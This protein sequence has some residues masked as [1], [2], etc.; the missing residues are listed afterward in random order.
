VCA[1]TQVF[2]LDFYTVWSMEYSKPWMTFNVTKVN[3]TN[4][5]AEDVSKLKADLAA[6]N[7]TVA[8]LT[9]AFLTN[10]TAVNNYT[11]Y[12]N[13][14]IGELNASM[15]ALVDGLGALI[16]ELRENL[17]AQAENIT[18]LLDDVW[19]LRENL[20]AYGVDEA[21]D[22]D[23]LKAQLDAL[24][25]SLLE[26]YSA[27]RVL[28]EMNDTALKELA[29]TNQTLLKAAIDASYANLT[30]QLRRVN[31]S[32]TNITNVTNNITER[33]EY[34]DTALWAEVGRLNATPPVTIVQANNTTVVNTTEVNPTTYVNKTDTLTT[35]GNGALT[36]AV[37]GVATGA[38]VSGAG[39]A[40]FDRRMKKRYGGITT[41]EQGI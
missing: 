17:S 36:G 32:I 41:P 26:T 30:E 20:T 25:A 28:M 18:A 24:D 34:N 12:L 6:L 9:A 1:Y 22:F 23:L 39:L 15:R 27:L 33:V 38:V 31:V 11:A 21:T 3:G 4:Q 7:G 40:L 16:A 13:A 8:N 14:S 37:T 5:M 19:A 35:E 10:L 29:V 2:Y